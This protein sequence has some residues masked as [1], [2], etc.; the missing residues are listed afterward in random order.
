MRS[1]RG[2]AAIRPR[3]MAE[4]VS[5]SPLPYIRREPIGMLAVPLLTSIAQGWALGWASAPYDPVWA[6]RHPRRR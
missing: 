3:I 5:L 2:R 4:M 1:S 6:E